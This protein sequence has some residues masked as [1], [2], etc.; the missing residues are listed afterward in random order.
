M[1]YEARDMSGSVFVNDRKERDNQPDRTGSCMIDGV[2]YWVNGWVKKDKNGKPWMSL[3]FKRKDAP[4]GNRSP[5]APVT[6]ALDEDD[7][8]F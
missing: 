6:P 7:I 2:E 3:A 5:A 1:A 8:P 4:S